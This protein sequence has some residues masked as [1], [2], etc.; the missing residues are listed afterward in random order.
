MLHNIQTKGTSKDTYEADIKQKTI[1]AN[2]W[3]SFMVNDDERILN[4]VENTKLEYDDGITDEMWEAAEKAI[5][6]IHGDEEE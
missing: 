4:I 3:V 2:E 1:K 5:D 6:E